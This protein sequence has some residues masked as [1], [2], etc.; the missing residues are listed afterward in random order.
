VLAQELSQIDQNALTTKSQMEGTLLQSGTNLVGAGN[1]ATQ[2]GESLLKTGLNASGLSADIYSKIA[3]LDQSQQNQI[4]QA[5]A[6]FA[7]ALGG[8]SGGVNLKIA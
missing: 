6:N 8:T 2:T 3:A 4:S 7:K 5:I 1:T